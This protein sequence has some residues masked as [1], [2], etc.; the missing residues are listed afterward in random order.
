MHFNVILMTYKK[1]FISYSR[2]M[3]IKIDEIIQLKRPS[4]FKLIQLSI[5]EEDRKK[6][7]LRPQ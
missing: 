1:Y 7:S 6:Q 2:A 5:T 3:D 4:V